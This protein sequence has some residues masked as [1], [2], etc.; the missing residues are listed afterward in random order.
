MPT[1]LELFENK[2]FQSKGL[3]QVIP[4]TP[5]IEG[6]DSSTLKELYQNK[7]SYVFGTNYSE[8]KTKKPPKNSTFNTVSNF[9]EQETSGLRIRSAVELPN[10]I[11]YGNEVLR[12]TSRET[13]TLREMQDSIGTDAG[14][15]GLVGKGLEKI[16]GGK[17]GKKVFGGKVTSLSGAIN[18]INKK[19]GIPQTPIPT[20]LL[21][22]VG[23]LS[24]IEAVTPGSVGGDLAGTEFGKFLKSTG[25]GTPKTILKQ[26]AGKGIGLAKK[27]L[28]KSL[29]EDSTNSLNPFKK[30][31]PTQNQGTPSIES[32]L[33]EKEQKEISD[34]FTYQKSLVDKRYRNEGGPNFDRID[35]T[36]V[37][38]IHGIRRAAS[39]TGGEA[40]KFGDTEYAFDSGNEQAVQNYSPVEGQ[41]YS[42]V[43]LDEEGRSKLLTERGIFSGIDKISMGDIYDT[44]IK[45]VD[46]KNGDDPQRK[47]PDYEVDVNGDKYRDLIPLFIGRYNNYP[48]KGETLYPLMAF[49]CSINGLTENVSPSWT[50]N[51]FVGNPYKYYIYESVE[52]SVSFN[53][54][55]YCFNPIELA[56]NWTKITNL[57]KLAYP[58]VDKNLAH[59]NFLTF[60]L[61]DMYRGKIGILETLTY[62][63]PDNGT[64]ETDID[65]LLLPKF[66]DA[67]LTIKFV[68]NIEAGS[69]T[70]LYDFPKAN[71]KLT[72]KD[73]EEKEASDTVSK[74]KLW[75]SGYDVSW[76]TSE[77]GGTNEQ[78]GS[79]IKKLEM[80]PNNKVNVTVKKTAG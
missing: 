31:K 26:A 46:F 58:L 10:P 18:G 11:L 34:K 61:G 48:A 36:K 19:L 22:D 45:T 57:T 17:F 7:D 64:W 4:S 23:K 63:F 74:H 59:P 79:D 40:G 13:P 32:A 69:I 47:V 62:T 35:L 38:P 16:S 76:K 15:G 50:S 72:G 14:D 65:G 12:I 68:E 1:I 20:R 33:G 49:R 77:P 37:S 43:K 51:S 71:I 27:N 53:L 8:V 24:S 5:E 42:K 75:D 54:Q 80:N 73:G 52:R 9:A 70:G 67:A 56:N 30:K 2:D 60:S 6:R 41:N 66:I 3:S 28:R 21:G 29:F 44:E 39:T 55:L 78:K 25:G